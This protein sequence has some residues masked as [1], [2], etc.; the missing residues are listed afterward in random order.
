MMMVPRD[1]ALD[2]AD[3]GDA[4]SPASAKQA[5]VTYTP[6][7]TPGAAP[8]FASSKD[9]AGELR[10][11]HPSWLLYSSVLV[12]LLQ[13]LQ[14]GWSTSQLNLALF[15]DADDCNTRP[16]AHG[17]CLMFPGHSKFQWTFAVNAWI[18]GGMLGSLVCGGFSDALGRRKVLMLNCGV[19]LIGAAV[20]AIAA[21]LWVFAVGRLLAGVASGCATGV[22]GSY[23]NE[24]SPPHLR[25]VL[26]VGF[27]ISITLGILLVSLT[28]FFANTSTGWRYIAGF[29]SVLAA[30]FFALAPLVMVESPAWLLTRGKLAEAHAEIARLYGEESVDT[31]V[32]WLEP[33]SEESD[34]TEAA[35]T[36]HTDQ[37]D[38]RAASTS[39]LLFSHVLVRQLMTAVA[40]CCAQQ[41]SGINAVFYY[42]SA[43][44]RSA[45][46]ADDRVGTVI[47]NVVNVLPTFFSGWLAARFGNRTMT[48]VGMGIM[49]A[50]AVGM[51]ISLVT[52]VQAL[53]I[54]FTA[55]YVAG[56][57]ISLGPLVWVIVADLFPDSVRATA[58]SICIFCNWTSNL[59]VGISYPY[60]AA[61]LGDFGF[62][63]FVASLAIFFTILLKM[64]P[65]TSGLTSEEIQAGFR[66]IRQRD[67]N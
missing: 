67:A 8:D 14:Y 21:N 24:V 19:I 42:S 26:G 31:V 51:T 41:L 49:L 28:F 30:A 46:I 53:S 5:S 20:Q 64:L 36:N 59:V 13:P 9:K 16:V 63:P 55:T 2:A 52:D 40:L 18:V 25:N 7:L 57:G 27:Q 3:N 10:A 6:V 11:V 33:Q 45:G 44:F 1:N 23:I 29:P 66:A 35:A 54:A 43:I 65:E 12:A 56:F 50:S 39:S 47:I 4:D 37:P 32:A 58:S 17:T 15:N 22:V 38:S 61:A 34:D 60:I 48:L 62:V